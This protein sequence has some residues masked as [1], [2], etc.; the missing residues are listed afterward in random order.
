MKTYLSLLAV[1]CLQTAASADSPSFLAVGKLYEMTFSNTERGANHFRIVRHEQGSW[2]LVADPQ[3]RQF[4]VNLDQAVSV[5]LL[6]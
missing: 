6:D 3:D 4:W 1:L 2:Y 5:M